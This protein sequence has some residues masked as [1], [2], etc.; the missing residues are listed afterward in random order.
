MDTVINGL[1]F[2]DKKILQTEKEL[3]KF[4]LSQTN[5]KQTDTLKIQDIELTASVSNVSSFN[6]D[7]SIKNDLEPILKRLEKFDCIKNVKFT[8]DTKAVFKTE[9]LII[10]INSEQIID[11]LS[12]ITDELNRRKR[13]NNPNWFCIE[14]NEFKM[15]LSDK[16][17]ISFHFP[18][19]ETK[20]FVEI[21][22][23]D[24]KNNTITDRETII[25]KI[26]LTTGKKIKY[27][28]LA[29][30]R[31]NLMKT[32]KKQLGDKEDCFKISYFNKEKNTYL[33]EIKKP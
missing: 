24:F 7:R 32:I 2:I 18:N 26:N 23:E 14:N 16:T 19:P 12:K 30:L 21:L 15:F 13:K 6:K 27:S 25:Q 4:L 22:L 29:N 20:V 11:Y 3:I 17:S 5:Y 31:S 10:T 28:E 1:S 33:L 8:T 9:F